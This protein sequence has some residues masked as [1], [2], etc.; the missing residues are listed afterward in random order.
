MTYALINPQNA[1]IQVGEIINGLEFCGVRGDR[2]VILRKAPGYATL[3]YDAA[4]LGLKIE[5][6]W[7]GPLYAPDY[8]K[9][10]KYDN[11]IMRRYAEGWRG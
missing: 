7:N 8:A 5:S 4:K 11:P 6:A 1:R 2:K 10:G 3:S 9:G